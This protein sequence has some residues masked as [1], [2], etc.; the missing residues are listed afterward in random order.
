MGEVSRRRPEQAAESSAEL[1]CIAFR[2][3]STSSL[4]LN[5]V[6]Y[7]FH[8]SVKWSCG[9]PHRDEIVGQIRALADRYQLHDKIRLKVSFPQQKI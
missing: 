4:Q 5:S 8:P 7:R 2:V 9:F 3:N 1:T 6:L